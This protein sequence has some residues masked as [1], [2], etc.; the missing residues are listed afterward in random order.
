LDLIFQPFHS[1]FEKGTGLGLAIVHR[2]VTDYGGTINVASNVGEGTSVTVRL[3]LRGTSPVVT[4][5]M[6][7]TVEPQKA[8][9]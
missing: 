8:V 5:L 7:D 2:I 1:S 3:P 4:S 6:R 9:V